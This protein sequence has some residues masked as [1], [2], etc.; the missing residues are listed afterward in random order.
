MNLYLLKRLDSVDYDEFDSI[1]V[2][3]SNRG[4]ARVTRPAFGHWT[5]SGCY[6][7]DCDGSCEEGIR[8]SVT[9][10]GRTDLPAGVIHESFCAG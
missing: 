10:I 1:V 8:L 6:E 3:A 2:A 5:S 4:A 7:D 9:C